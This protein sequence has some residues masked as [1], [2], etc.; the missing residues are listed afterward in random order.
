MQLQRPLGFGKE[1]FPIGGLCSNA[2]YIFEWM[3]NVLDLLM[4]TQLERGGCV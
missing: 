1:H 2:M 3:N 4:E